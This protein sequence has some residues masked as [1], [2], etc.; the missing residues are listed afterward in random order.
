MQAGVP[1]QRARQQVRLAENLES[2]ADAEYWQA[3]YSSG[4][5]FSHH[6]SEPGDGTAAQVVAVGKAA[7]HDH[8]VHAAQIAV[9]VP[10]RDRRAAC[11][12]YRP[13]S[14]E[15]IKG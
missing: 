10:E 1:D 8:G 7:E 3:G 4:D 2:V 11:P 5:Q 14:V 9:A 12:A 13:G 15:I 6:G